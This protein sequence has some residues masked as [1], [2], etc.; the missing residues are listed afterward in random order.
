MIKRRVGLVGHT[1]CM[2]D[3]RNAYKFS[4]GRLKEKKHSEKQA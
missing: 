4:S 2:G 1:A 3:I